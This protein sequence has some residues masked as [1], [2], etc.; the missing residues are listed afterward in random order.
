MRFVVYGAGAVGGVIGARLAQHGHDVVLIARGKHYEAIRE[1][2]ITLKT[3]NETVTLPTPAAPNPAGVDWK[4]GDVCLLAMKLQDSVAALEELREAAGDKLPVVCVQNGVTGERFALRR[5]ANVYG[6]GVFL[7]ATHLEPGVVIADSRL[8]TGILDTGR[9]PGGNDAV[10]DEIC[11]ALAASTFSAVSR[12]DIMAWKY[13]KLLSNLN[14]AIEAIC[15]SGTRLPSVTAATR[16]EAIACY[17]AAGIEWI[18]PDV[19]AER[20]KGLI[21]VNPVNQEGRAGNSSWQSLARGNRSIEADYLNG[22]ITLLGRLHGIPTPANAV[23]QRVANHVARNGMEPGTVTAEQ[24]LA[25][26][27]KET[28]AA[29][30]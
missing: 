16:D 22:E 4:P 8:A 12:D 15:G 25:E 19:Y 28:V 29:A 3:P 18:D 21:D 2:G 5:F 24:L 20:R 1:K 9:Y 27:E 30:V 23:L 6:T 7:P 11:A 26:I 13:T 17:D 14:N 10:A